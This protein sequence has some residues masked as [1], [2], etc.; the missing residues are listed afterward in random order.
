MAFSLVVSSTL[1]HPYFYQ[2]VRAELIS[3]WKDLT[4]KD[5]A[6]HFDSKS[7]A[8]IVPISPSL[9][10]LQWSLWSHSS[11]TPY[12]GQL[13]PSPPYMVISHTHLQTPQRQPG[14]SPALT[15]HIRANT[16]PNTL[17]RGLR[18][19]LYT[20]FFSHKSESLR[21]WGEEIWRN[22]PKN[23]TKSTCI[24]YSQ[25]SILKYS[26]CHPPAQDSINNTSPP[27]LEGTVLSWGNTGEGNGNPLQ[28]S[29]LENSHEQRS[30]AGYSPWDWKSQVR[31]SNWARRHRAGNN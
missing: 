14:V 10:T 24:R 29:C 30:L 3:F 21:S 6:C 17:K 15:H 12:K 26:K 4:E 2:G 9:P 8:A 11:R 19:S 28:Y 27:F 16:H 1:S 7:P 23:P 13:H 5:S 20:H 18:S 31:Q 22:E 25:R